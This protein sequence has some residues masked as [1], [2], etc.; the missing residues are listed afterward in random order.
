EAQMNEQFKA[1]FPQAQAIVDPAL[2][3][4]RNLRAARAA[5]G[6]AQESDFLPL[7]AK[8]ARAGPGGGWTVKTIGY[9]AGQLTLDV[10][11]ADP[12]QADSMLQLL[13]EKNIGVAREAANP[14]SSNHEA[15][16]VFATR[17][18]K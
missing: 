13:E 2:Q 7:L 9:D 17:G 5:A 15:R 10:V 4:R 6:V 3:M 11:L 1:A 18:L 14:K 8:V 16:F 12:R